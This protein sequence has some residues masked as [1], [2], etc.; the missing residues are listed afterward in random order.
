M[1]LGP[2]G[3]AGEPLD[4]AH[5]RVMP[6]GPRVRPEPHHLVDEPE[7][8]LEHVLGDHRRAVGDGRQRD[9]HRLQVRREPRVG[10]RDE[11]DRARPP[12]HR[13]RELAP[14]RRRRPRLPCAACRARGRGGA[15]RRRGR[16]TVPRVIAAANA[17]VAPTI[18]S[19]I[20]RC[21]VGCRLVTPCTVSVERADA[22]DLGAHL[23]QHRAQVDD[24][25]FARG[26]VD[27]G[28]A[29]GEHGGHEDV[30]GGPDARE[31]EPDLR[32]A[33]VDRLRHHAAVLDLGGRT[34]LAQTRPGACPAAGSRSRR[35]RAAGRPRAGT[36]RS[37][38]R[39]R[40]PTPAASTPTG[41]RPAAP[42]SAGTSI[43]TSSRS[44]T[45]TQPR[46]RSTSAISGTSRISGQLVSV[47][48]PSASRA[49]AIS[50]EHAVL[51]AHHVD[52]ARPA[53]RRRVPRNALPRP[54]TLASASGAR[55]GRIPSAPWPCT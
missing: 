12:V 31:V 14:A 19:P 20:T 52:R 38:G 35:R 42:G 4:A 51:G 11:V 54:T 33:Q 10:Q 37:A 18:R 2:D 46:L 50:F 23:L 36:A 7:P 43:V 47:V 15:G 6:V 5:D 53:G 49:A 13:D 21:A 28:R 25:G 24:L 44:T 30:L 34:E 45:T 48:V 55:P 41:S 39:A 29:L 40:T 17:Q 8:G 27:H 1:S 26:V 22:V 3:R 32:P 9:R 16:C